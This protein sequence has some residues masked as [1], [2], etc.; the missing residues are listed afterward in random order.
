[1]VTF[2]TVL[3]ESIG[4]A[5]TSLGTLF[6]DFQQTPAIEA[7][8]F[9]RE[10]VRRVQQMRKE[11]ALHVEDHIAVEVQSSDRLAGV[12]GDWEA[13]IRTETRA[14][15]FGTTGEA[16]QGDH[17]KTWDLNGEPVTIGLRTLS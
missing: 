17:V 8:A 1:M 12:F 9:A 5:Q 2:E 4:E 6:V 3:A 11:M 7:E 10:L 16:P 14:E 13:H 15:R